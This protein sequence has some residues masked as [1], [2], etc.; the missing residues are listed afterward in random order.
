VVASELLEPGR[1]WQ[2]RRVDLRRSLNF[3]ADTLV[4]GRHFRILTLVDDSTWECLGLVVETSL[5]GLRVA[6][7]LDRIAELRGYPGTVLIFGRGLKWRQ[8]KP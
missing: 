5:T 1:R 2:C 7:D 4:S 8:T 3:V 6:R